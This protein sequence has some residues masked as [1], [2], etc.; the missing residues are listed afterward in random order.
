M[1]FSV[2]SYVLWYFTILRRQKVFKISSIRTGFVFD[3]MFEKLYFIMRQQFSI[4]PV[5]TKGYFS[6]T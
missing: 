1:R 2:N 3:L 6:W 5:Q 4:L